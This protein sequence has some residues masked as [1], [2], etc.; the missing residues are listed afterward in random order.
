M[1]SR[2][3]TP[4]SD[5]GSESEDIPLPKG[6]KT[7]D[8]DDYFLKQSEFRVWLRDKKG[9]FMDELSSE[10]SRKY[11]HKFVKGWNSGKLS[12]ELYTG[13]SSTSAPSSSNTAYR[14]SFAGRESKNEKA[15]LRA[16]RDS[17]IEATTGRKS[18][19]RFTED[20]SPEPERTTRRSR[21]AGPALPSAS[22]WTVQME[23][24]K[25]AEDRDRKHK[26]KRERQEDRDRI[27]DMV[28]PKETGREGI[29]EKK[30]ARRE[31]D[32]KVK[33]EK[34][35]AGVELRDDDLYGGADSFQARLAQRD[36]ARR[37]FEEKRDGGRRDRPV[38]GDD[39]LSAR[40]E[41][42]K[43]TMDHFRALAKERYG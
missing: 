39:R 15:A 17:V 13:V 20:D 2:R 40:R 21:V 27:E 11:F 33:A 32:R 35:D 1:S 43:A 28:G 8:D 14:W 3:R 24:V 6:V 9:K 18:Y 25:E 36:A 22:D 10:K 31:E 12:D 4:R 29:L 30:R 42:E 38:E 5:D 41:K 34:E 16:A 23:E 19:S 7:I 26:R 37:R